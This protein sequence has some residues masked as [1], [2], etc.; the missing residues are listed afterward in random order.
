MC[1]RFFH[2]GLAVLSFGAGFL[3]SALIPSCWLTALV[4]LALIAV[5]LFLIRTRCLRHRLGSSQ[6]LCHRTNCS[7]DFK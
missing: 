1:R 7:P 5:G 2:I 6:E 4:G 3:I